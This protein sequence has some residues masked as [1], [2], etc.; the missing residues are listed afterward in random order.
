M[1]CLAA[2]K[3]GAPAVR[4]EFLFLERPGEPVVF[5]IGHED[6]GPSRMQLDEALAGIKASDFYP[7]MG[8]G[9]GECGRRGIC[10]AMNRD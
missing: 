1:Y 6:V 7:R 4:M 9:C 3:A 8:A 10:D 5:D 2:L